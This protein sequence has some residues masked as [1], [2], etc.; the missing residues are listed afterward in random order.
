MSTHKLAFYQSLLVPVAQRMHLLQVVATL[1]DVNVRPQGLSM[2]RK[3]HVFLADQAHDAPISVDSALGELVQGLDTAV[4][5]LLQLAGHTREDRERYLGAVRDFAFFQGP[6]PE[7]SMVQGIWLRAAFE[8]YDA[9][10]RLLAKSLADRLGDSASVSLD[11]PMTPAQ[12]EILWDQLVF[13]APWG[14]TAQA[15][16]LPTMRP[17]PILAGA[18]VTVARI[19]GAMSWKPVDPAKEP[20]LSLDQVRAA[21]R[22]R[23]TS[24]PMPGLR[25]EAGVFISESGTLAAPS[26]PEG[27]FE[28]LV[29][30]NESIEGSMRPVARRV[31]NLSLQGVSLSLSPD[32]TGNV[33]LSITTELALHVPAAEVATLLAVLDDAPRQEALVLLVP[34]LEVLSVPWYQ[35]SQ[36][37]RRLLVTRDQQL[38]KLH[39]ELHAL[40]AAAASAELR[41]SL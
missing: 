31:E 35:V 13:S 27:D 17:I 2:L 4:V 9:K 3:I 8:R 39:V 36:A 29:D 18:L 10:E 32:N 24:G 41:A 23:Y 7:L 1:S 15:L 21:E 12:W 25:A 30:M 14:P 6:A 33:V 19:W 38:K 26:I 5:T 22:A 16:N 40:A 28:L 11:N 34:R 20:V 37:L